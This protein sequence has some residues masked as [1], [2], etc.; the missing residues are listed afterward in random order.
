MYTNLYIFISNVS[1][2]YY[3]IVLK[4]ACPYIGVRN[5]KVAYDTL[6]DL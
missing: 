3:D 6:F 1:R 5:E 4:S 2:D